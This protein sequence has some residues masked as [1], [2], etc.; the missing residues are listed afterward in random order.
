MTKACCFLCSFFGVLKC[1][2][3]AVSRARSVARFLIPKRVLEM[4]AC[5]ES[6]RV[7]VT[8]RFCFYINN[9]FYR[10]AFILNTL[11]VDMESCW[12]GD[13]IIHGQSFLFGYIWIKSSFWITHVVVDTLQYYHYYWYIIIITFN[14]LKAISCI[15]FRYIFYHNILDFNSFSFLFFIQFVN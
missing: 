1:G 10:I 15:M 6:K 4:H 7:M 13:F 3:C 14:Y 8:F 2:F 9:W 11:T 12:D 5:G